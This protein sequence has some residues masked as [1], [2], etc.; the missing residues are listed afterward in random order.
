MA[1]YL[2]ALDSPLT[3]MILA[4]IA[5]FDAVIGIGIVVVGEIAFLTAGAGLSAQGDWRPVLV[6]L[7]AAWAG[8]LTSFLL[9][10][11]FG[12]RLILRQL[13][14]AKRRRLWRRAKGALTT[15]G[16]GFVIAARLLGPVSWVT[17]FLAGALGMRPG[18]FAPAS[19]LGVAIGAGLFVLYGALG[20]Q[21]LGQIWP[22]LADHLVLLGLGLTM[23]A[24]A[25]LAWRRG[26]GGPWR[27]ALKSGCT[28][29]AIFLASNFGYF[30]VLDIHAAKAAPGAALSDIC[31]AADGPFQASAGET[32]LHLPQPVNVI[33]Y[34]AG[35]GADLMGRLGWSRNLTFTHDN[36]SFGRY[37][38]SLL[39]TTPPVSELY[40]DGRPADSAFQ[41]PGTL[42]SREHIRWW[43]RGGNVHFG[44]ISRDDEIAVKYYGHLPVILHDIDPQ[45]D[46]SRAL[47]EHQ[48]GQIP[49]YRVLGTA[50][51]APPVPEGATADYETDGGVLLI[52]EA[53]RPVPDA[54]LTCLGLNPGAVGSGPARPRLIPWQSPR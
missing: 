30:F 6:V 44:A 20:H 36:I 25:G 28:A 21:I 50:P 11:R 4:L 54:V 14:R 5:F 47:L 1:E 45:V 9:G 49:G 34:S 43:H 12:A 40:L 52:A 19:A 37:L 3:L 51:L 23:A 42:K 8:D 46:R 53:G 17:P 15:H 29:L 48:L 24:G 26:R 22:F 10:R 13:H 31:H 27:K 38:L 39:R 7:M 16:A 2:L 18:I 41:M 32:S 35:S 33:L